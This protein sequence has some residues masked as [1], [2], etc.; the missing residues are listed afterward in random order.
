MT[1]TSILRRQHDAAIDLMGQVQA[2]ADRLNVRPSREDARLLNMSLTKLD[3]LL[4]IHFAQEDWVL[5]PALMASGQSEVA[6]V[7]QR[8]FAEIGH[9]GL[10]FAEFADHWSTDAIMADMQC[11]QSDL[12]ALFEAL[13]DRIAR[14]NEHLYPL[15]DGLADALAESKAA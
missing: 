15:A 10:L 11:F 1:K 3:E 8:F 4:R 6:E 13:A 2:I 9:I 14:E 5:Y 7:A 12:S